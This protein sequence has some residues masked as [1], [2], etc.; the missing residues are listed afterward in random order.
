[1]SYSFWEDLELVKV[2]NVPELWK[3]LDMFTF[4]QVTKNK[5]KMSKLM[6]GY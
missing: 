5:I 6:A 2:P 4:Q 3:N 1:M